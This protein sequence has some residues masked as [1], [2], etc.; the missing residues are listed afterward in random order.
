MLWVSAVPEGAGMRR[1]LVEVDWFSLAR[2]SSSGGDD[3]EALDLERLD[4]GDDGF[5]DG[6]RAFARG[7][8]SYFGHTNEYP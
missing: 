3:L 5:G 2:R 8:A 6:G 1:C 4:C 7:G